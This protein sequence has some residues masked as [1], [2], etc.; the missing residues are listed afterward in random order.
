MVFSRLLVTVGV[1][2]ADAH[3]IELVYCAVDRVL[4]VLIKRL[5]IVQIITSL[6][7]DLREVQCP[8]G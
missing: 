1:G 8:R 4:A 5:Q 7:L 2:H 6:S 3:G